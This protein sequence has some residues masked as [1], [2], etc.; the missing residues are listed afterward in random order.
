MFQGSFFYNKKGPCH[1]QE[2]ETAKEKK[3]KKTDLDARN[4]KMK[5]N[6]KRKQEKEQ[7]EQLRNWVKAYGKNLG[8]TRK[9]Q[10]YNES[11]RAFIIKN[12]KKDIN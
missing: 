5:K 7:K 2:K 3:E 8:R 10:K 6:N 1:V 12:R 11:T 4:K 9:I